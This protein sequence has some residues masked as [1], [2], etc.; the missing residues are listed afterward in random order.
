MFN[1]LNLETLKQNAPSIFSEDK[2]QHMSKKYQYISTIKIV[3]GLMDEG[4]MPTK[5]QQ[6]LCRTENKK[7]H[8]KHM[9]RFRHKDVQPTEQG[10]FPEL[11]LI[12]S[13]DGSSSYRLL[14]G[15]YRFICSNGLIAGNTYNEIRVRHQG[16][17]M[18]QVIEG[19]YEVIEN[20]NKM[21][22]VAKEMESIKLDAKEMNFYAEAAHNI[23]FE[24]PESSKGIDPT[25]LLS[26]RRSSERNKNDLFTVFNVV[27]ENIIKGGI[28]GY[29]LDR[30]GYRKLTTTRAIKGIDQDT[31]LNR[32]LWTLT[33]KMMQLKLEG[34]AI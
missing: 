28:R 2:Y 1:V 7:A 32:A 9:I 34:K 6:S 15:I 4:F 17:I 3:E 8:T 29:K 18:G 30:S 11:V 27:Q 31:Y 10:L 12:N 5:A 19:T 14:S 13:H 24:D 26:P 23:R 22:H 16:N 33:E 25:R 21:L 20:S